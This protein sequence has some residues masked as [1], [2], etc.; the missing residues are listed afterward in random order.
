MAYTGRDKLDLMIGLALSLERD[1]DLVM[2]D[3]L[4]TSEVIKDK[5]YYQ[6]KKSIFRNYRIKT[7]MR[8]IKTGVP[9]VAVFIVAILSAATIAVTSIKPLR[10]AVIDAIIEWRDEYLT[11]RYNVPE[12]EYPEEEE[13]TEITTEDTSSSQELQTPAETIIPPKSI[14]EVRK[15]TYVPEGVVENV[16]TENSGMVIID[17]YCN[18]DYMFSFSQ[19]LLTKIAAYVDNETV[20]ISQVNINGY[21][22]QAVENKADNFKIIIWNDG[23]YIY[24]IS[25]TVYEMKELIDIAK[26]V[27]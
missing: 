1:K 18:N 8:H 21:K 12:S 16:V 20:T 22:A 7:V 15:P 17:Y 14:E 19:Q 23:E 2:F 9:K 26:S 3:E 24:Q 13:T 10:N 11:I 4:D 27:K 25:S 6:V 5:K